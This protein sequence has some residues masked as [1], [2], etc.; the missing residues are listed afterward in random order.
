MSILNDINE[1]IIKITNNELKNELNNETQNI[2]SLEERMKN[3]EI[4]SFTSKIPENKP[5]IIRLNGSAFMKVSKIINFSEKYTPRIFNKVYNVAMI[6]ASQKLM[7]DNIFKPVTIYTQYDEI[8]I[9]FSSAIVFNQDTL[10]YVSMIASKATNY[11]SHQLFKLLQIY[12]EH[13]TYND[14]K[15]IQQN[16]P[17]FEARL[18]YFPDGKENEI[19]NYIIWRYSKIRSYIQDCVEVVSITPELVNKTKEEQLD[20]YREITGIDLEDIIPHYVNQGVFIK[21]SIFDACYIPPD[22][23]EDTLNLIYPI[24]HIWS[25]KV[26]YSDNIL[27]Q[28]MA[29]YYDSEKW[30]EI[31]KSDLIKLWHIYDESEFYNDLKIDFT[32]NAMISNY[33]EFEDDDANAAGDESSQTTQQQSPDKT[34]NVFNY[35]D[36]NNTNA[37]IDAQANILN[38]NQNQKTNWLEAPAFYMMIPFWSMHLFIMHLFCFINNV[39][40]SNTIDRM[41]YYAFGYSIAIRIISTYIKEYAFQF[42]NYFVMFWGALFSLIT[43]TSILNVIEH[44]A[45]LKIISIISVYYGYYFTIINGIVLY[46]FITNKNQ[47]SE[48]TRNKYQIKSKLD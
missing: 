8:V 32:N 35:I 41:V 46:L 33:P 44:S 26:K 13:Y 28:I 24:T 45:I 23:Q 47:I 1:N 7:L 22:N 43:L 16:L 4:N 9:V 6:K 48:Q 18:V 30:Q 5:F 21:K 10:K 3:Y 34:K 12:S 27:N 14:I 19:L 38:Q 11:F 31:A 2:N 25:M 37:L 29:K 17:T 39:S 36:K 42:H 15:L 40:I 20:L